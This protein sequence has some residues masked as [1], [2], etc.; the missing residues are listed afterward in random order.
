MM[1]NIRL[2]FLHAHREASVLTNELTEESEQFR[3]FRASSC[4]NLKGAVGL[5]MV[6]ASVMR[7]QSPWTFPLGL[8]YRFLFSFVRVVPHRF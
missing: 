1:K 5:I 8:P 4:A 6:K 3:F 2:L 7:I